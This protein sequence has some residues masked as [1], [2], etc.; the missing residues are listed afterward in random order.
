MLIGEVSERSGISTRMLRHYDALEL[1]TASE[2]TPNGYRRYSSQDIRRLFQ[3]EALRSLGLGLREIAEV[4]DGLAFDAQTTLEELIT[5]TEQR[6]AQQRELLNHLLRVQTGS[7]ADWEDVLETIELM[8]GLDTPE[9]SDRLSLALSLGDEKQRNVA[10]LTDA[11][12]QEH[13]TNAAGALDWALARIGDDIIP[14]VRHAL[15][16]RH[17]QRRHRAV[18]VLAKLGSQASAAALADAY[19]HADPFVHRRAALAHGRRGGRDAIGTLIELIIDGHEDVEAAEVLAE[20]SLTQHDADEVTALL[21]QALTEQSAA[22]RQRLVG[23]LGEISG[24]A[25]V[26]T[27]QRLVDDPDRGVAL[28]AQ[29]LLQQRNKKS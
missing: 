27:I 3:V 1:V 14:H 5:R 2:R 9:A 20:L 28:T 22:G 24:D 10:L 12:L 23:A 15:D 19:P 7:P 18:T 16:S 25:A 29:H 26:E 4:I 13:D 8:H 17:E 11:A 21:T 6:I